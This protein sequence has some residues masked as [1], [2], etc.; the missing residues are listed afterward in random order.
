M[1]VRMRRGSDRQVLSGMRRKEART[2][3]GGRRMDLRVRREEHGQILLRVRLSQ[4]RGCLRKL[5]LRL[6]CHLYR[7]VLSRLR[8]S[9]TRRRVVLHR[10]RGEESC[11]GQVLRGLW[12]EKVKL[13]FIEL[14]ERVKK[15]MTV[16]SPTACGRSPLGEGAL[17]RG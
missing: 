7:Q 8:I 5:D 13:Q 2:E 3:A 14:F 6:R 4:A 12:E 11:Y 15:P 10:L 17:G 16:N 1:E 9:Q